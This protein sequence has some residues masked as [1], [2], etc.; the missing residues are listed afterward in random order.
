M[1]YRFL[2]LMFLTYLNLNAQLENEAI[3]TI[4]SISTVDLIEKK[5]QNE[6]YL[7]KIGI[8]TAISAASFIFDKNVRNSAAVGYQDR[9]NILL[10][11]GHSYGD[12]YYN[13]YFSGAL[14]LSQ[15]ITDNKDVARTGKALF[16]SILV[17][18]LFSI[19]I[20]YIFGRSR[21]YKEDGS[22]KFNWFE[23]DNRN[24]SLPS[25]HVITAFTTST[26]LSKWID[27]DFVSFILYGLAGLT[28]SQRIAT[29][30]HWF[31]DVVLG[32]SIGYLVADYF[33][34]QNQIENCGNKSYNV[35]PFFSNYGGG[36]TLQYSF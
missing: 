21:P 30:N 4:K 15:F 33:H 25:G 19:S 35:V 18:S 12:F 11:I 17:G 34:H 26:I 22:F 14:L 20:K 27:N 2:F 32:A 13:I 16:E 36:I 3:D 8:G 1:N 24:N 31:S 10:K 6:N 23:T 5:D 29:D 7:I 9:E 28:A